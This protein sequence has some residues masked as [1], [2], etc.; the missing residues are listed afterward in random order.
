MGTP[1]PT[2]KTRITRRSSRFRSR[3]TGRKNIRILE[4]GKDYD[5][6]FVVS[7][8]KVSNRRPAEYEP[9]DDL[10]EDDVELDAAGVEIEDE[11]L[12]DEFQPQ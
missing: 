11:E 4:P 1:S 7:L 8:K 2:A 3:K 12:H 10:D 6:S 5:K 9:E